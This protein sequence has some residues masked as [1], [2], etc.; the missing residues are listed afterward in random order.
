MKKLLTC[1]WIDLVKGDTSAYKWGVDNGLTIKDFKNADWDDPRW[2]QLVDQVTPAEFL[3]FA[4]NA[5]HNLQGIPS[6]GLEKYAADDG[7]GGADTNYFDK[8]QFQGQPWDDIEAA[9]VKGS[10]VI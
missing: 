3:D 10:N 4:S 6:V 2:S 7:P 8:G 1:D 9:R 5:F